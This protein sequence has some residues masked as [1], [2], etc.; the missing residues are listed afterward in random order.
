MGAQP[1]RVEDH[2]HRRPQRQGRKIGD[3]KDIVLDKNGGVAYAVVSTGGFLGIGDRLHAVPW[4]SL[5]MNVSG[6]DH[7]IL[8][9]DKARLSKVPGFSSKSWPNFADD[10]WDSENRKYYPEKS[11][12]GQSCAGAAQRCASGLFRGCR[13]AASYVP[14]SIC[15]P[16]ARAHPVHQRRRRRPCAAIDIA[17]ATS[18]A[19]AKSC[20]HGA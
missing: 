12:R 9:I 14:H 18:V 2:R 5:Q 3:V 8:D 16:R 13:D 15:A 10:R 7:Y 20:I 4:Q 6:K 17:I 1:S 19:L 11:P